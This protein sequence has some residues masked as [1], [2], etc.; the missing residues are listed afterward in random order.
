MLLKILSLLLVVLVGLVL[1]QDIPLWL[2]GALDE[3]EVSRLINTLLDSAIRML[4]MM[5]CH[6]R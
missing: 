5:Q 2:D 3:Y 1:S 4:T 6:R